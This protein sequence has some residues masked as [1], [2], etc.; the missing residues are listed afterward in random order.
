M[1]ILTWRGT[2]TLLLLFCSLTSCSLIS[3]Q[4][5]RAQA[6]DD[7]ATDIGWPRQIQKDGTT[8]TIYQPQVKRWDGN[9]LQSRLTLERVDLAKRA[10]EVANQLGVLAEEK[11]QSVTVETAGPVYATVDRVVLRQALIDLVDNAIKYSPEGGQVRVAVRDQSQGPT[12]TVIDTEPG[13]E[14]E[15]H[16][17]IFA[18]FYRVD[19]ACSREWGGTG[20]GLAI[21]RW[22]VEVHGG[23]IELESQQGGGSTFRITLSA[24]QP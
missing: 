7:R 1:K 14:R 5:S 4:A 23:R 6:Q 9:Q 22:T 11:Q 19:K 24:T 20:L 13:I 18:R 21:A 10:C 15:H 12:L 8:I 17:R 2:A 16:D 3:P